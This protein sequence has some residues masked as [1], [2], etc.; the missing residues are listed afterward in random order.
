M[1]VD[2]EVFSFSGEKPVDEVSSEVAPVLQP[3]AARVHDNTRDVDFP[4]HSGWRTRKFYCAQW[5]AYLDL[6][7]TLDSFGA[8]KKAFLEVLA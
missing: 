6:I 3:A 8:P 7:T 1:E 2:N 4:L 5:K